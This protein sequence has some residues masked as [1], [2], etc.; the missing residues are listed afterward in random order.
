MNS[1]VL[2]PEVQP[3]VSF[4][5]SVF[6]VVQPFVLCQSVPFL[7]SLFVPEDV[8]RL[9]QKI[10]DDVHAAHGQELSVA[11]SIQRLVVYHAG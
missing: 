6:E 11:S 4:I 3:F 1:L 8:I 9:R 10:Q 5:G 7:V 2:E